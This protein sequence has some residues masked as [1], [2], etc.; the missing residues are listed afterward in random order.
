[1]LISC[2]WDVER[3]KRHWQARYIRRQGARTFYASHFGAL[4]EHLRVQEHAY[5]GYV[6]D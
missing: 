5:A 4:D 3:T 2:S 1:M 6:E